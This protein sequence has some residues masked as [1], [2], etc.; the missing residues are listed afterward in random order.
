VCCICCVLC[1]Q[2]ACN[3]ESKGEL[4]QQLHWPVRVP[5]GA[6]G[7]IG[8]LHSQQVP[9]AAAAAPYECCV[10]WQ[11]LLSSPCNSNPLFLCASPPATLDTYACNK[12]SAQVLTVT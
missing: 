7:S 8:C 10:T 12:C 2:V 6:E 9:H 4:L 5:M 11:P 3:L 1:V